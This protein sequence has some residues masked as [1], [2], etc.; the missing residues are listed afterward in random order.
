MSPELQ[1]PGWHSHQLPRDDNICWWWTSVGSTETAI[2]MGI[3][4]RVGMGRHSDRRHT[5]SS[6]SSSAFIGHIQQFEYSAK[7]GFAR[8][9]ERERKKEREKKRKRE[10]GRGEKERTRRIELLLLLFLERDIIC[11]GVRII[12]DYNAGPALILW[13]VNIVWHFTP[14]PW[15]DDKRG[16]RS[17][18]H[19]SSNV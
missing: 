9:R 15:S 10:R 11:S 14:S 2:K 13:W 6:S 5:S 7:G 16:P 19:A 3:L 8:E 1:S 12:I 17:D 4:V 18:N